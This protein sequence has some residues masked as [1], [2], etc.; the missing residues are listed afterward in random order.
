M[1]YAILYSVGALSYGAIELLFRGRTHWTMLLAGGGCLVLIYLLDRMHQSLWKTCLMGG[2][3][4]TAVEFVTGIIVNILLGWDVWSYGQM[5]YNLLGQICPLF[6][7]FWV[8]LS[9]PAVMLCR[10]L[11]RGV[12]SNFKRS[13]SLA[14]GKGSPE[15]K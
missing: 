7:V 8:G 10:L 11:D 4:I 15:G 9:L 14:H 1:K 2:A 5:P 12:F 6:T 3:V 13:E